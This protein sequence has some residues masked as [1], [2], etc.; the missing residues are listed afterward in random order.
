M[1]EEQ[2]RNLGHAISNEVFQQYNSVPYGFLNTIKQLID[3]TLAS[4]P[5]AE[6]PPAQESRQEILLEE[7]LEELRHIRK[8]G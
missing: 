7:I 1:T 4:E 2:K 6:A 3:E 5:K 8:Y